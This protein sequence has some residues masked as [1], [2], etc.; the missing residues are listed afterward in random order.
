MRSFL[1]NSKLFKLFRLSKRA[2]GRY[3][4]QL[5]GL[6]GLGFLSGLLEGIGVNALI[7]VLSFAFGEHDQANDFI[8]K[9]LQ[10][11]F[12]LIHVDFSIKFLLIFIVLLFALKALVTIFFDYINIR[13]T[14]DYE[15]HTRKRLFERMLGSTWPH[16]LKQKFGF[17]ENVLMVDV[18][19]SSDLLRAISA[20]IITLAG[21]II[22]AL[23]AVNISLPITLLTLALGA[24]LFFV[25]HPFVQ[26]MRGVSIELTQVNKDA[27]HVLSE[28]VMGVKSIKAMMAGDAIAKRGSYYFERIRNLTVRM[29]FLKSITSAAVLPV[30]VTY[31]TLIFAFS[32]KSPD[33]GFAALA[34]I[35]YLVHRIFIQV[36]QLQR[37]FLNFNE[38]LPRLE[39]VLSYEGQVKQNQEKNTGTKEFAFNN[40]LV[41]SNVHFSYGEKRE[42]LRG[43]NFS[44]RKGEFIGLIGPSGVGKTTL[45]DLLLRLFIPNKGSI[46]IDGVPIED[47]DFFEWRKNIGYV[48]QDLFLVNDTIF[49]NIAFYDETISRVDATQAARKAHL[50]DFI[51]S[52]PIGFDTLIGDRGVLLSAGQRQRLVIARILA[53][54]SQILILDEATSALDNESEAQIQ[55]VV[56]ELKGSIT[57]IAIAHRLS[58]IMDSDRLLIL[59]NGRISEE[60]DPQRLVADKDSY[61]FKVHNIRN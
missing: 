37:S 43:V 23:V 59:E 40:K 15:A 29:R 8:S 32:Y 41:F 26:K 47:I 60:G 10:D 35:I 45:T 30:G 12:T 49:N 20:T 5:V 7:P 38:Y 36:Q 61:F 22:Y 11:F 27:T 52:L 55:K 44:I 46:K 25:F 54:K 42:V 18:P 57:V 53:K 6:T 34:A 39:S 51:T 21:L 28:N 50:L 4:Y 56:R 33:F 9:R 31:I 2:F 24:L 16:L 58:T 17:L 48:S 14:S 19:V 1:S 13:I 3:R